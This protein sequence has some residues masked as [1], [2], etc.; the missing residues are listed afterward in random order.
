MHC[1]KGNFTT[2]MEHMGDQ[3]SHQSSVFKLKGVFIAFIL[4]SNSV[5]KGFK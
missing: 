3:A 1:F 4:K 5:G 2:V